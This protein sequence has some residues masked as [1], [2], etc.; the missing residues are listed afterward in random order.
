MDRGRVGEDRGSKETDGCPLTVMDR[1][2][3][4]SDEEERVR[5]IEDALDRKRTF[6][7]GEEWLARESRKMEAML[8]CIHRGQDDDLF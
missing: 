4:G 8:E 6:K 2:F 3:N 7:E 5:R 1:Y